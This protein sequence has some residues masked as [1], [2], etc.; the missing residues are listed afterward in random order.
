MKTIFFSLIIFIVGIINVFANEI[1]TVQYVLSK[2]VDNEVVIL[3]GVLS[4]KLKRYQ[5]SFQ[6]TTGE[7]TV[8][9]K[10]VCKKSKKQAEGLCIN[11]LPLALGK[12][13]KI[14]VEV[15]KDLIGKP[16][17]EVI[18][19]KYLEEVQSDKF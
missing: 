18:R 14:E 2:A 9:F 5:F 4:K 6:D 3:E 8:D 17:L 10:D 12:K 1:S 15:D 13:I 19:F 7:I 11:G 16:E